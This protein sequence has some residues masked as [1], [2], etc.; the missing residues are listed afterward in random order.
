MCSVLPS[1][2]ISILAQIFCITRYVFWIDHKR[3]FFV[4]GFNFDGS[5]PFTFFWLDIADSP[6][7]SGIPTASSHTQYEK[8][9][10]SLYIDVNVT[11]PFKYTNTQFKTLSVWCAEFSVL[12]G[13]VSIPAASLGSFTCNKLGPIEIGKTPPSHDVSRGY[14]CIGAHYNW[15]NPSLITTGIHLLLGTGLE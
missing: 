13:Q 11:F 8:L 2:G 4:A 3:R 15:I 7:S 5:A 12:F 14:V 1:P 10:Y 9:P 6:S